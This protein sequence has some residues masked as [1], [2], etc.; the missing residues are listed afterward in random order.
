VLG[1]LLNVALFLPIPTTVRM[2]Y[3]SF[4]GIHRLIAASICSGILLI[5]I[6]FILSSGTS[7]IKTSA[8]VLSTPNGAV[9]RNAS[10]N[11]VQVSFYTLLINPTS[12]RALSLQQRPQAFT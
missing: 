7:V 3:F 5:P 12:N 2:K 8:Q 10:S 11:E 1:A 4:W 9:S 6:P